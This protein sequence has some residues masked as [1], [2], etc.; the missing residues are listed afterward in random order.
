MRQFIDE[1]R[2]VDDAIRQDHTGLVL[3]TVGGVLLGFC[4]IICVFIFVGLRV[5]SLFWLWMNLGL[6]ALG[7]ALVGAGT[8]L[9]AQAESN[10]EALRRAVRNRSEAGTSPEQLPSEDVEHRAA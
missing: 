5:G 10:F 6:G 7:F 1:Q 2:A 8:R 3:K 9:S 4:G